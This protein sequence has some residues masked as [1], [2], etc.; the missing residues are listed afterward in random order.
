MLRTALFLIVA[1]LALPAAAQT[2]RQLGP[3][4][5]GVSTLD[6]A[7]DGT[8]VDLELQSPGTD[9]VGF[10]SAATTD[11]EKAALA[12]ATS[13]LANPLDVFA[14]PAAAGCKVTDASQQ[15]QQTTLPASRSDA[16]ATLLDRYAAEDPHSDV[17]VTYAL[18]CANPHAIT[19]IDFHFFALF[20]NTQVVNV[21]LLS[22]GEDEELNIPP[23]LP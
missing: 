22:V 11:A 16:N 8:A 2:I 18:T 19:A 9:I 14:L 7:V 4:I 23:P 6:I 12:Q 10:E 3:H 5:H 13:I 1:T 20:P 15:I 17:Y 21:Q